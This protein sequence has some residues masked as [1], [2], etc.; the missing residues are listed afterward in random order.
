MYFNY[1]LYSL[2]MYLYFYINVLQLCTVTSETIINYDCISYTETINFVEFR[3]SFLCSYK[4]CLINLPWY[5]FD[6]FCSNSFS[7]FFNSSSLIFSRCFLSSFTCFICSIIFSPREIIT[8]THQFWKAKRWFI[9]QKT[10]L[11]T[12]KCIKKNE[13]YSE[14]MFFFLL[15]PLWR[16]WRRHF[17]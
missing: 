9:S 15:L 3:V 14:C 4:I 12:W 1:I 5:R 6:L 13:I 8:H 2:L 11:K 10:E 7:T 16:I 17:D